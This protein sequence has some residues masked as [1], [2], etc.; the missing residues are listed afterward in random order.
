M[1]DIETKE[2]VLQ[3]FKEH[4]EQDRV[5]ILEWIAGD[6]DGEP[7]EMFVQANMVMNEDQFREAKIRLN[8]RGYPV[9]FVSV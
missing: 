9:D 4:E 2:H 3:H 1:P 6:E 5:Q 8:E 7:V